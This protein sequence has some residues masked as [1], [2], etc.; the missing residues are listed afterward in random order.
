MWPHDIFP[1]PGGL[2]LRPGM[3]RVARTAAPAATAASMSSVSGLAAG[4]ALSGGGQGFCFQDDFMSGGSCARG[5]GV[6]YIASSP[7]HGQEGK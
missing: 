5:R 2:A 6:D 4:S 3:A 7:L 1:E